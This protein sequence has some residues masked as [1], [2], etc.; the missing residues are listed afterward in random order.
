MTLLIEIKK[1]KIADH[2]HAFCFLLRCMFE[3]SAKAY[4]ADHSSSGGP[5][6]CK[7][8]GYDKELAELLKEIVKH[9]TQD[10]SDK[11]KQK[12]LHGAIT[13]LAKKD[14]ILSI[15]SMNQ[16]VHNPFFSIQSGDI[17]I[18]FHNIFPLL[19]AMN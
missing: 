12:E 8:N 11:P 16:L 9:I 5:K 2:P 1:L 13:E 15:T 4:C 17:C 6:S 10:G 3:L 18:L 19:E 7:N 14:G